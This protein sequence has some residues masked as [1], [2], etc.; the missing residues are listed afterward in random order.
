M[1]LGNA[2]HE[3]FIRKPFD[4]EALLSSVRES[5]DTGSPPPAASL[6]EALDPQLNRHAADA[7]Q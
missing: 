4:G 1:D 7:A 6:S 5:L 2:T 3:H